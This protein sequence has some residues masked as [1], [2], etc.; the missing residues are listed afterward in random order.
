[1]KKNYFIGIDVSK[2]TLD[3]ALY[4]EKGKSKENHLVI[5]NHQ[6]GFEDFINWLKLKNIPYENIFICM[7]HT[8]LYSFEF[9]FFL[10]RM[11]ICYCMESGLRIKKSIGIVRGKNDKI[12]A[13]CIAEYCY[14]KR[15]KLLPTLM[16]S[17][18]IFTLRRLISERKRYTQMLAK[19]KVIAKDIAKYE[20]EIAQKRT[21]V[22]IGFIEKTITDIEEDV[23][24]II[25]SE[26]SLKQNYYLLSTIKGIGLVN[27][28]NTIV[29]TNNF[30]SFSSPREYACYIGV[31]PFPN[32][33]G[34]SIHGKTK[35]SK[36]GNNLSSINIF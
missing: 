14:E 32:R 6:K 18:E 21:I 22:T 31:A 29:F 33:S 9:Q 28:I 5:Q 15:E 7:E 35:V 11:N 19:Y 34:S 36:I 20:S 1:M 30:T 4:G 10:E 16:P 24:K 12:D 26:R 3:I 27:A 25:N 8:G 13:F 23:L 2:H 17:K